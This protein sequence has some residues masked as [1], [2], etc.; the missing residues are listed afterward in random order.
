MPGCLSRREVTLHGEQGWH[1][2]AHQEHEEGRHDVLHLLLPSFIQDFT[3]RVRWPANPGHTTHDKGWK[4]N[5]DMHSS[6]GIETKTFTST[7]D[8]GCIDHSPAPGTSER[9][10]MEVLPCKQQATRNKESIHGEF[11]FE[12]HQVH[13]QG[14]HQQDSVKIIKDGKDLCFLEEPSFF[15]AS[16]L[17]HIEEDAGTGGCSKSGHQQSRA[18]GQT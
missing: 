3:F 15:E 18:P 5:L 8:D 14:N 12:A 4:Q 1:R 9:N 17:E 16:S 6:T 7:S 2:H 10:F 11:P 13:L